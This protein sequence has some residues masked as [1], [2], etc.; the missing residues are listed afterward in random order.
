MAESEKII[1][2][3][4]VLTFFI[5]SDESDD[6]FE[7]PFCLR[8]L[9]DF[10]NKKTLCENVVTFVTVWR[11]SRA[12]WSLR[13]VPDGRGRG[14][15]G[16][17]PRNSATDRRTATKTGSIL[18][19]GTAASGITT[20]GVC[21]NDEEKGQIGLSGMVRRAQDAGCVTDDAF[22]L[23]WNATKPLSFTPNPGHLVNVG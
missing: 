23:I 5:A 19:T 2:D 22:W 10:T 15:E 14:A 7:L 21:L 3:T 1:D 18:G 8:V 16:I 6:F 17:V 20:G 11:Q 4:A 13:G 12:P 9:S